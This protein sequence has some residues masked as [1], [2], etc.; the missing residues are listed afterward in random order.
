M[1]SVRD[2]I[3]T[4]ESLYNTLE[5]LKNMGISYIQYSGADFLSERIKKVSNMLDMKVVLTHVSMDRILNDTNALMDEHASFNCYNIGLGAMP[6]NVIKDKNELYKTIDNLE[7]AAEIMKKNGFKFFYHNHHMEFL[8]YD[9]QTILDYIIEN[10]KHINITLDTYWVQYGGGDIY[11]TIEKLKDRI[12]CVHLKDY[13]IHVN[14]DG[15][16]EPVFAPLGDGNMDFPKICKK[17]KEANTKYFLIEQDN[18]TSFPCP[19][20]Q[21]GRS[22][23]Y[24]KKYLGFI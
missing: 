13:M 6:Q 21:I 24:A 12:E 9:G 17:M 19:F 22:V 8:K 5:K 18:A 10:A 23:V 7:K 20:E 15:K 1:Y 3:K 2:Q 4:E 14:D 16:I 11:K